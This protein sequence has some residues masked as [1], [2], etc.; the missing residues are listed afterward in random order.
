MVI[1]KLLHTCFPKDT[2]YVL[3]PFFKYAAHLLEFLM[4]NSCFSIYEIHIKA[5]AL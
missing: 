2:G 5:R 3:K 1:N 4:N